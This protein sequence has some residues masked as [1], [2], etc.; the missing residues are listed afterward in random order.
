MGFFDN[1]YD[2]E[3]SEGGVQA[4]MAIRF[5][6]LSAV[7]IAA[8]FFIALLPVLWLLYLV[9]SGI[10]RKR[11]KKL[12]KVEWWLVHHAEYGVSSAE[13]PMT[14]EAEEAFG[15][16][17]KKLWKEYKKENPPSKLVL[18]GRAMVIAC[19]CMSIG[20]M[21][22]FG[23]D[24]TLAEKKAV[25]LEAYVNQELHEYS[26]KDYLADQ[27]HRLNYSATDMIRAGVTVEPGSETTMEDYAG[28]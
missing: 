28:I 27:D 12:L 14:Q 23:A 16:L 9:K 10:E 8:M 22:L 17:H 24:K 18:W 5:A 4:I 2:F 25:S 20:F 19:T 6:I 21:A 15:R 7:A 3:C 1:D 26:R 13:E 11:S